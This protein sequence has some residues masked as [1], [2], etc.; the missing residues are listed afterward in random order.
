M[1]RLGLSWWFYIY[2]VQFCPAGL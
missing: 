2:F 1:Q